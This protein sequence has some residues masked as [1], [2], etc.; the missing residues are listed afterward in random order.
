[1]F[2]YITYYIIGNI[3]IL[4]AYKYI[5]ITRINLSCD[6]LKYIFYLN[7]E[8]NCGQSKTYGSESLL[9]ANFISIALLS[10]ANASSILLLL[11]LHTFGHWTWKAVKTD[12]LLSNTDAKPNTY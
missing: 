9:G 12:Y 3:Y 6:V 10:S 4:P 8:S 7:A 11:L 2:L 1:M 5:L